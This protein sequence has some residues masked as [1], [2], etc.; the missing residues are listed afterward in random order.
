MSD[1]CWN[2]E[3]S[4]SPSD[5]R[6]AGAKQERAAIVEW[7]LVHP[8]LQAPWIVQELSAC[9]TLARLVVEGIEAGEHEG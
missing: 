4:S 3:L 1:E 2:L 8:K 5:D 9:V 7:L 6:I